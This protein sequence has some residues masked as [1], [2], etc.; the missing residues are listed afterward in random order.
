MSINYY[1]Y[2]DSYMIMI[3]DCRAEREC[4]R[5]LQAA[6]NMQKS[7]E[8]YHHRSMEKNYQ[9]GLYISQ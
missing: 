9:V 3:S 1:Y 5:A 8:D 6:E 2:Y 7:V 4:E